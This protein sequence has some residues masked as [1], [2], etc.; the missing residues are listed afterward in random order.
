MRD[1]I[2]FTGGGTGGH[3][4]PALAVL[5]EL[6]RQWDGDVGWVGS[7]KGMERSIVEGAGVPYHGI[8]T[9]KLRRYLSV[10]NVADAFR[11]VGGFAAS[12]HLLRTLNP[13]LVFS[14]G[15]YVSV[16]PLAAARLLGIPT[17]THESDVDP[18]LATRINARFSDHVLL[19]YEQTRRFFPTGDGAA[20]TVT[21]NPV[22]GDLAN[23][24]PAIGRAAVGA[25]GDKP[26]LLV[27]GGSQGA[28]ELNELLERNL[29]RLT[30][31]FFVVHQ[32]GSRHFRN[33][34]GPDY[35]PVAFFRDEYP[36]VLAAADVVL[37]R[38]GAATLWELA[39]LEKPAVLLPL[40][41]GGSRGDQIR[42]AQVFSDAG[43]AVVLEAGVPDQVFVHAL[44]D[45]SEN[46]G[47]RAGMA[48]A[49]GTF[50]ARK[51]ARRVAELVLEA[52]G[53]PRGV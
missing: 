1:I 36:H 16:P 44:V 25:G 26:M 53:A 49:A 5:D 2:L 18:G 38:A 30:R 42:N 15:G 35:R 29:P 39:A 8:P 14:K 45:L 4:F 40:R 51:A 27:L 41:H 33:A 48:A 21:G 6:R 23:A 22:R 37:C 9:G 12:L 10:Q 34:A 28:R 3:V 52:A 24:D 47:R 11:V 31:R 17:M 46:P 50:A 13:R 20:I 7:H 43:A 32:M 19:S